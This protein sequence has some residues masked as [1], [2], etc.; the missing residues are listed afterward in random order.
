MRRLNSSTHTIGKEKV[1][2][3]CRCSASTSSSSGRE[4]PGEGG[5]D[6]GVADPAARAGEG[7]MGAT[8]ARRPR[9]GSGASRAVMELSKSTRPLAEADCAAGPNRSETRASAS[10]PLRP[11][12]H[13]WARRPRSARPAAPAA[14]TAS[15][16]DHVWL[17]IAAAARLIAVAMQQ[18]MAVVLEGDAP[19]TCPPAK[20]TSAPENPAACG[21]RCGCGCGFG[22]GRAARPPTAWAR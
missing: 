4:G 6:G 1:D 3:A 14:A 15:R 7:E 16:R 11:P 8:Q 20:R 9:R 5:G 12:T 21:C 17:S 18:A 22:C 10:A 19:T 2:H 13:G